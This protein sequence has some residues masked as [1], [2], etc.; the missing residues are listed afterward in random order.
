MARPVK[1]YDTWRIRWIDADGRRQSATFDEY[2][3]AERVLRAHQVEADEIRRGVRAGAPPP[4]MFDDLRDLWLTTRAIRKRSYKDDVSICKRLGQ[5]FCGRMLT[6]I[7]VEDVDTYI[8]ENDDLS[9]KTLANHITLLITMMNYA[10][11]L[12]LPWLAKVPKF[13]KPKIQALGR[14]YR[15]LRTREEIRRFLL[16]ARDEGETIFMLYLTAIVTGMRAGELAALLWSDIDFEARIIMVSRSFD[17]PTKSGVSRPVPILDELLVE[18]RAWRLRNAG[19]YVFPNRDGGMLGRSGRPFQ[20][21]LHRV[22]DRAGFPVETANGKKRW[23]ISFHSLRHTFASHW[24]LGGGSLF[25][26]QRVL[27]HSTITMTERYSHLAPQAFAEDHGRFAGTVPPKLAAEMQKYAGCPDHLVTCNRGPSGLQVTDSPRRLIYP[28]KGGKPEEVQMVE[29][30]L[31]N[32][33]DAA[34]L[35]S[36]PKGTLYAWVHRREIPFVRLGKRVIRFSRTELTRWLESKSV[37][38]V[39]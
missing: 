11:S 5:F 12:K 6:D 32:Y 31:L 16:A 27:G 10:A 29:E 28:D 33:V 17:G 7:G 23:Y 37:G 9:P 36:V 25:R 18:L 13:K 35:L 38:E 30:E 21:V 24:M 39:A 20:E 3:E 1:H 22:L 34:K 26:L 4:K 15:Y 2:R 19:P 14:N 8:D